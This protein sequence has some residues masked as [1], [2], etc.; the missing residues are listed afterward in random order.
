MLDPTPVRMCVCHNVTFEELK[1]AGVS[2][3][4]EIAARFGCGTT[5]GSCLPYLRRML[6][7]GRTAFPLLDA[8]EQ[9]LPQGRGWFRS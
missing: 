4:D 3:I 1:A 5:C 8:D 6:Q 7:T 2:S 9:D